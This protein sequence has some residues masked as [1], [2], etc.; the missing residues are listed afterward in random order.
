M[1]ERSMIGTEAHQLL[2]EAISRLD[3]NPIGA[4]W[5][6]IDAAGLLAEDTGESEAHV[7]HAPGAVIYRTGRFCLSYNPAP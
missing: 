5:R 6:A 3:H 7:D 1:P 4:I 2:D